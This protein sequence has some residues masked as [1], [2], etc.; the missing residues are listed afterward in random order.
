M[1][2]CWPL[3]HRVAKGPWWPF[4]F[5]FVCADE[6]F[7]PTTTMNPCGDCRTSHKTLITQSIVC[8]Q[9]LQRIVT[10]KRS[11][12][13]WVVLNFSPSII[14]SLLNINQCIV[15]SH[16]QQNRKRPFCLQFGS[17]QKNASRLFVISPN[18]GMHLLVQWY[19]Q[20]NQTFFIPMYTNHRSIN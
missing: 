8:F 11:G 3:Y 4:R 6:G 18:V 20:Y 2:E 10:L 1:R 17:N 9:L 7:E 15:W 19:L 5:V 14:F 12:T 13:N 16:L